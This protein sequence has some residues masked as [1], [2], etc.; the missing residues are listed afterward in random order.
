M[1]D[2]KYYHVY[3]WNEDTRNF[4]ARKKE[5]G[6][7]TSKYATGANSSVTLHKSLID[8]FS[9]ALNFALVRKL[10]PKLLVSGGINSECLLKLW[11]GQCLLKAECVILEYVSFEDS[12]LNQEDVANAETLC[13]KYGANYVKHRVNLYEFLL[14]RYAKLADRYKSRNKWSLL[15]LDIAMQ[16]PDCYFI[17]GG[18]TP[19]VKGSALVYDDAEIVYLTAAEM[20]NI[21]GCWNFFTCTGQLLYNWLTYD[22]VKHFSENY[23]SFTCN[24]RREQRSITS[25]HIKNWVLH[26]VFGLEPRSSVHGFEKSL[27]WLYEPFVKTGVDNLLTDDKYNAVKCAIA[28]VYER[29]ANYQGQ[30]VIINTVSE[31]YKPKE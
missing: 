18:G 19:V 16:H 24:V 4:I 21:Q 14:N 28:G 2:N 17:G 11:K 3:G 10:T 9:G 12:V 1:Y 26:Q 7:P 5:H 27:L 20:D 8:G 23:L 22:V 30:D 15:M 31:L 29:N 6:A 25:N 13:E